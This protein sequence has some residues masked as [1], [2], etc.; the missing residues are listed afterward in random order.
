M[1]QILLA[2][3]AMML[4]APAWA[5]QQAPSIYNLQPPPAGAGP[6]GEPARGTVDRTSAA[7]T[8][9]TGIVAYL[10]QADQ[11]LQRGSW[12]RAGELVERAETAL[13]N[14]HTAPGSGS[15]EMGMEEGRA[16]QAAAAART[17]LRERDRA[18]AAQALRNARS[19]TAQI[20]RDGGGA[21]GTTGMPRPD[22][23]GGPGMG[24]GIGARGQR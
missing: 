15:V 16:L 12:S 17:A 8:S 22:M 21:T 6:A 18:A 14:R 7:P 24:T 2:A 23:G 20:G 19:L 4:A 1:R 10:E 5:Q 11:A 13:L 9:T 3:A